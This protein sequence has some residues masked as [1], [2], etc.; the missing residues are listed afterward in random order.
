MAG[1]TKDIVSFLF[2]KPND[3]SK[4]IV[5]ATTDTTDITTM[6][7]WLDHTLLLFQAP[8]DDTYLQ[9]E[10][11]LSCQTRRSEVKAAHDEHLFIVI[12]QSWYPLFL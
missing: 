10:E 6:N 3:F 7:Y 8:A 12:H 11:L 1:R 2:K 9:L 5:F 4:N